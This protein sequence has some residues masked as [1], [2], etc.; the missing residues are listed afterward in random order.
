MIFHDFKKAFDSVS[1]NELLVK[2]W[3]FGIT[4]DLWYWFKAYLTDRKQYV[5]I[6]NYHSLLL[7]VIS[8]VA[9]GSILGPLLFLVFIND[10]PDYVLNSTMLPFA[11]DVKC[12]LSNSSQMD[13][14]LLQN[15]LDVLSVWSKHWN[16]FFNESKCSVV[17][18]GFQKFSS[19]HVYS[20]NSCVIQNDNQ[21]K[22]LGI[23][24]SSDLS[25]TNHIIYI[26]AKAYKILALLRRSF[27]NCNSVHSKKLLYISLVRSLLIYGSQVW[28]PHL[29]KDINALEAIQR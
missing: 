15:D 6:N 22:D 3:H 28:H 1:H 24:V 13:W 2:L 9:Q 8:G 21:H 16:L 10:L 7:P 25:W 18:F 5:S 23:I 20:I 12:S 4:G 14:S 19:S 17:R 26:A 11:D 29:L 27:R